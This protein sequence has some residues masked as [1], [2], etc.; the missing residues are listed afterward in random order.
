MEFVKITFSRR[1]NKPLRD[2]GFSDLI[3][4]LLSAWRSNG[5]I[6]SREV[7]FTE[8][9][10]AIAL[11]AYLPERGALANENNG[12]WSNIFLDKLSREFDAQ[13]EVSPLGRAVDSGHFCECHA[14]SCYIVFT[15]YLAVGAPLRCGD[16]FAPPLLYKIPS[17]VDTCHSDLRTWNT[18]YQACDDLQMNCGP[19]ERFAETQM[20]DPNSALS[21]QGRAICADIESRTGVPTLYYLYQPRARSYRDE[22][23]RKCPG[24]GSDWKLA[25]RQHELFDFRCD[26]CRLLSNIAFSVKHQAPAQ[27]APSFTPVSSTY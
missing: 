14:S 21:K 5:Q 17:E 27:S 26:P 15:N 7:G 9:S 18:N 6:L 4:S 25:V 23:N 12:K 3:E 1:E 19:G 2:D 20:R 16:C 22:I 8:E 10:N 11:Y 24:C 13:F